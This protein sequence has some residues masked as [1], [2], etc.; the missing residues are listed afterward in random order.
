MR[1]TMELFLQATKLTI[2][3]AKDL[4]IILKTSGWQPTALTS[5]IGGKA[6]KTPQE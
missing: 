4:T 3:M 6:R 1:Y 2:L 5:E